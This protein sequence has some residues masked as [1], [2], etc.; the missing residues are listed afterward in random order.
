MPK[1]VKTMVFYFVTTSTLLTTLKVEETISLCLSSVRPFLMEKA[2]S[3]SEEIELLK[4]VRSGIHTEEN[5]TT[6]PQ[7]NMKLFAAL[8]NMKSK[9]RMLQIEAK[10]YLPS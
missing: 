3:C 8:S 5:A 2:F 6:T 7:N 9:L 1:W 4:T 10:T